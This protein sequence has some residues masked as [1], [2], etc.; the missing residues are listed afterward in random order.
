MTVRHGSRLIE[1]IDDGGASSVEYSFL[2]AAI[3]A[4]VVLAV[5][6]LGG[7]VRGL[8]E[9]TCDSYKSGAVAGSQTC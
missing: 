9:D 3:A 1:V 2:I 4:V 7:T 5:F 8:F 6:T